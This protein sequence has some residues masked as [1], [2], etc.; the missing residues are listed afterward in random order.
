MEEN[1][2]S[3]IP[4]HSLEA[5]KAVI[6]SMLMDVEAVAEAEDI[7]VKEDFYSSK[8]GNIFEAIVSVHKEQKPID[9]TI[10]QEKLKTNG[11]SENEFDVETLKEIY[12]SQPT[13]VNVRHYAN[14]VR[15]NALLRML[16]KTARKIE[17]TCYENDGEIEDFLVETEKQILSI[18]QKSSSSEFVPISEVAM[19]SLNRINQAYQAGGKIT[20]I[21]TG[22]T[23]ID[24]LMSGLRNSDLILVAARPSMGKTAFV[25]N[26]AQHVAVKEKITTVIFSLEMS[27]GQL[28]DRILS[29]E[30]KVESEKIKKGTLEGSEWSRVTEA[31]SAIAE[32]PLIIDDTSG[33]KFSQLREKCRKLKQEKDLKLIIIDYIQLMSGNGKSE[34]RQQEVSEISRSLKGLARELDIPVI[35]LSQLSRQVESRENKRPMLSDL[36]ESGAIE[37]DADIVMFIYREDY[38]K[39][40]TEKKGIAEIIFAKHR[41]GAIGTIEL[42]WLPQYTQFRNIA[43]KKDEHLL[44]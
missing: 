24:N 15:K 4:P 21:P 7:L 13:S 27:K 23:D 14:I 10:I 44:Q 43:S 1:V 9:L 39:K 29:M 35:A 38:Y 16:A 40:D 20:G 33:I 22:F 34:S 32:S 6:G 8:Y 36:R 25:L 17:N 37:Q 11:L 26:I 42:M 31:A 30:S 41:S 2:I 5:E 19:D 28:F 12:A 18:T 3:K